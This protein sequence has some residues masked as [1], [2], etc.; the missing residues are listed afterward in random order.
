MN[1]TATADVAQAK[2]IVVRTMPPLLKRR[3]EHFKLTP[4]PFAPT[5]DRIF[6]M[7]LEDAD[8]DKTEGG[9]VVPNQVKDEL[10]SGK[11]LLVAAGPKAIEQLY[12]YGITL[13][14]MVLTARF[15]PWERKFMVDGKVSEALLLRAS[16]VTGSYDLQKALDAG[17][18]WME[19][20]PD[21]SVSICD[22]EAGTRKRTDPEDS[23]EGI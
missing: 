23:A 20:D 18:L 22:R 6:V 10:S 5:F 21:G 15:S 11:G 3:L 2:P 9:I 4:P 19:M 1:V 13:G 8:N 12:G 16:E 14:H 7:P 17:D